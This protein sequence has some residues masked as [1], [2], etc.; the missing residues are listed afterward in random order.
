M[1]TMGA[2]SWRAGPPAPAGAVT[3]PVIEPHS[4]E[5]PKAKIPLSEATSQYPPRSAV[6]VMSMTGRWRARLPVEP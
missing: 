4:P 2:F 6:G 3:S 5:S 1:P